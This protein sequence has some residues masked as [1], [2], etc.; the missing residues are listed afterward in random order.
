VTKDT[1]FIGNEKNEEIAMNSCVEIEKIRV[2]VWG[3][4]ER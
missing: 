3:E 2:K 4:K 1:P